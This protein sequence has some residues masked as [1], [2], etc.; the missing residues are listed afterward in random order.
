MENTKA[1]YEKIVKF[2]EDEMTTEDIKSMP[3]SSSTLYKYKKEPNKI[4]HA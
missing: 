2:L 4:K 3:L 1:L